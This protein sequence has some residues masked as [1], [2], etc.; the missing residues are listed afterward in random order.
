MASIAKLPD[1]IEGIYEAALDP[2]RWDDVVG[3]IRDF[4]GGQA[5]GLF[6]KDAISKF[7]VTYYHCGADP[8]FIE[9]YSETYWQFDPL[10]VLPRY[11]EVVSIPDLVDYDQYRRGR[12]YQEWLAPQGCIDAANVVLEQS[13]ASC[14][15]LMTVLSGKRMVDEEM[16]QRISLIVPHANR[17]LLINK[18]IEVKTA[19]AAAFADILD[20]MNA[21]I[22][23]ID[24]GSRIVHANVSGRSLLLADD[25]L[26]DIGGC[27]MT[28]DASTNQALRRTFATEGDIERA[29]CRKAFA[30]NGHDGQRYVAHVL[31]LSSVMRG[32]VTRS[33]GAVGALL[34]RKE[35]LCHQASGEL[36][37]RTFDLTPTEMNV[38]LAIVGVG[39]VPETAQTLGIAVTTVKTHLSRVFAKTG[40]S[41]Q[42]D[43]VKLAAEFADPFAG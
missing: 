14:P 20:G 24:A 17:A 36:I 10:S 35:D 33:S 41:R 39:G 15:V 27:L 9:T 16:R 21:A 1:V 43:L 38:F 11:G 34:V 4:V 40:T 2:V 22:F 3:D 5:C 6:S 25:A 28:R 19:E 23:L 26:R 13:K 37:A 32:G 30:L 7:G 42:A 18:A 29:T 8:H 12:F 31:P